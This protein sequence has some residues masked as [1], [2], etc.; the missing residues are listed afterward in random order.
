MLA[1]FLYD[2]AMFLFFFFQKNV[3]DIFFQKNWDW[4]FFAIYL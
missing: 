2:I 3:N 4:F 1:S